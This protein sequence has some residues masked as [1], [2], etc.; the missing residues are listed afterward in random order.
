V[1]VKILIP[2]GMAARDEFEKGERND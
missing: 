2:E 1:L